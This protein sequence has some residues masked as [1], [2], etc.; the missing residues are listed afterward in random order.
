GSV[1]MEVKDLFVPRDYSVSLTADRPREPG[2]LYTFPIFGLLA[3]GVASVALGIARSAVTEL[4]ALCGTKTPQGSRKPLGHR[5]PRLP[6]PPR[7]SSTAPGLRPPTQAQAS[8]APGQPR[9]ARASLL[10][11]ATA[12]WGAAGRAHLGLRL[13]DLRLDLRPVPERLAAALRG[14]CA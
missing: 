2:P 9:P 14:L 7:A 11:A 3:L 13:R 10:D 8:A 5:P 4:V 6:R 12:A 1:D